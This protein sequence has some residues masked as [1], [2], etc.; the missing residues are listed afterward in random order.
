MG[1][2]SVA[3][4]Y[5]AKKFHFSE[6]YIHSKLKYVSETKIKMEGYVDDWNYLAV[7]EPA[8]SGNKIQSCAFKMTNLSCYITVGVSLKSKVEGT[9]QIVTDGIG[10]GSYHMSYDGYSWS[11]HDSAAN[12]HYCSWSF[13]Q[14]DVVRVE[15]NPK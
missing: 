3:E 4:T 14:G 6:K 12:S 1:E 9:Y 8:L 7:C 11:D 15:V 5:C 10:H 13:S 2:F